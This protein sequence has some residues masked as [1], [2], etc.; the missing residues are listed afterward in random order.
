MYILGIDTSSVELGIGLV[1]GTQP[2]LS[3]SRYLRNSHAEQITQTIDYILST[4]SISADDI[5][6]AAIAVGPGS[7]TGLRIGISFL[8]GF[9]FGRDIRVLPVSTLESMAGAWHTNDNRPIVAA[10]DAR[11]GEVFWA[12][13]TN[14]NNIFQRLTS[15]TLSPVEDFKTVIM[16]EDIL[17]T[18][19]LGYAKSTAFGFCEDRPDV[20]GVEKHPIQRGLSCALI[21][22]KRMVNPDLFVP[23]S[24]IMPLYMNTSMAE[25]NRQ[26]LNK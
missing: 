13:F 24:D 18:D 15:D 22:A 7:F 14:S 23:A 4:N 3:V 5:K 12:R 10:S 21:A 26:S 1:H 11:N 6:A 19:T 8:K 2:V 9:L 17:I 16:P 20:F 25:K